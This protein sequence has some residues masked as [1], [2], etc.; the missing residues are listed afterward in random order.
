MEDPKLTQDEREELLRVARRTL[1]VYLAGQQA[2]IIETDHS[3]LMQHRGAFVTLHKGKQLRGCIGTFEA[4]EP[5]LS[6]VQRM[7]IA[8]AT[9]D[10]RFSRVTPDE[11]P[12]I[13]IEIS[14]LSPL[15]EGSA[16]DIRVGV[17]GIYITRGMRR[18]VLLPQ[19]ATENGWDRETFLEHTCIKAGLPVTAWKEPDTRIEIFTAEV[20]GEL[21]S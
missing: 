3:T 15:R 7:A 8:A 5:L 11:L 2:P 19:V 12:S 13:H 1:E 14:A 20:F 9:T 18:G 21:G 6:T 10:P 4:A 17:H 16:D